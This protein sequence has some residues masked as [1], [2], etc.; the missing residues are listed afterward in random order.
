M[1]LPSCESRDRDEKG[2]FVLPEPPDVSARRDNYGRPL[3]DY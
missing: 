2:R 1:H 3:S